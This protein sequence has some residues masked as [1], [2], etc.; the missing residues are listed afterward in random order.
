M[1]GLTQSIKSF[2]KK[3]YPK[4][5]KKSVKR[6]S[7][8]KSNSASHSRSKSHSR[9]SSPNSDKDKRELSRKI[10][11]S[12]KKLNFDT[13]AKEVDEL[14]GKSKSA[15]TRKNKRNYSKSPSS[16]I[17]LTM[18][19]LDTGKQTEATVKKNVNT[20]KYEFYEL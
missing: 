18:K 5:G 6:R 9:M 3:L 14:H 11:K 12:Y 15:F 4:R 20:G 1:E 10:I 19:N 8:S 16:P 17:I 7:H 13:L 2:T